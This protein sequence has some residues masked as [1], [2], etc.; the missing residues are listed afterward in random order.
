MNQDSFEVNT[1]ESEALS[2][3]DRGSKIRGL[4]MYIDHQK[5]MIALWRQYGALARTLR[6]E[7]RGQEEALLPAMLANWITASSC[8]ENAIE[9]L[10]DH[11]IEAEAELDKLIGQGRLL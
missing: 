7:Y 8:S 11:V 4:R 10:D 5:Q 9:I 3:A 1:E 6:R 2:P